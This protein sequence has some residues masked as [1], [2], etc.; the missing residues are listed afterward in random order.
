MFHKGRNACV[1]GSRNPHSK[2]SEADV[3]RIRALVAKGSYTMAQLA[4]EH[5]V[6]HE[7]I[8]MIVHRI[9]WKHIK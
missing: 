4:R 1:L 7:C 9:K 8:R 6:D 2:L 5:G 3:V